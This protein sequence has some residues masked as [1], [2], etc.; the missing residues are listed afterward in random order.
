MREIAVD[1]LRVAARNRRVWER[2]ADWRPGATYELDAAHAQVLLAHA[3]VST[4]T[5]DEIAARLGL[6]EGSVRRVR[7]RLRKLG[8]LQDA[9]RHP[10]NSRQRLN[11][12]TMK[13][14]LEYQR[15]VTRLSRVPA[16]QDPWA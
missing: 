15:V 5:N 6:E 8:L 4:I 2:G 7:G 13:G 16:D 12:L 3:V 14:E 1:A 9:G 11:A 10:D